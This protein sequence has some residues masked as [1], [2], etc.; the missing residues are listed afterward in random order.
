MTEPPE[1][2]CASDL[3]AA[4]KDFPPE[5]PVFDWTGWRIVAA[6]LADEGVI[7]VASDD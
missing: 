6:E 2:K 7:L 1:I 4:L 5:A 3:I